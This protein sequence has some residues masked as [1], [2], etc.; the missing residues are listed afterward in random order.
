[1]DAIRKRI[2]FLLITL[3][4]VFILVL[5]TLFIR[6]LSLSKHLVI[7]AKDPEGQLVAEMI[8]QMLEANTQVKVIQKSSFDGTFIT[9]NA[10]KMGEIDLYVEYTGTAYTSI[11]KRNPINK[12]SEDI[13]SELKEE[14]LMRYDLLWMEP[15]GFRSAYVLITTEKFAQLYNLKTLS[16]LKE[17]INQDIPLKIA[18]DPEFCSR[19]E[20]N[21]LKENYQ[22]NLNSIQRMEHALLYLTLMTQGIDVMNGYAADSSIKAYDLHVLEDDLGCFPSYEAVPLVRADTLRKYPE[23]IPVLSFLAGRITLGKMRKM[24]YAVEKKGES[25]YNVAHNFLI[26]EGFISN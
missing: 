15:V 7:G 8:T 5:S 9:F 4:L 14:F 17:L 21:I 2:F 3:G 12:S 26:R 24:N 23:L 20:I 6:Q 19:P 18:F 25:I 1:M 13:F 16:D 11:L 22:M 10:L